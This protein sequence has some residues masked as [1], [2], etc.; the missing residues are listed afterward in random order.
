MRWIHILIGLGIFFLFLMLVS[1]ITIVMLSS[2]SNSSLS[3]LVSS[4]DEPFSFSS[5]RSSLRGSRPWSDG[6]R[7]RNVSFRNESPIQN[8]DK[9]SYNLA[10]IQRY[11]N[12]QRETLITEGDPRSFYPMFTSE[13]MIRWPNGYFED[14]VGAAFEGGYPKLQRSMDFTA[15]FDDNE[16]LRLVRDIV[17]I[18]RYEKLLNRKQDISLSLEEKKLKQ[19]IKSYFVLRLQGGKKLHEAFNSLDKDKRLDFI[20][21]E[22]YLPVLELDSPEV[23]DKY[24]DCYMIKAL[25]QDVITFF[26]AALPS[27][28]F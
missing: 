22:K 26:R 4:F 17:F 23:I 21:L 5:I 10:L 3:P 20:V 1:M 9:A 12:K 13:F 19:I 18:V 25:A 28:F 14:D 2:N 16:Y 7:K 15:P 27:D 6:D 11:C 8:Y 24:C